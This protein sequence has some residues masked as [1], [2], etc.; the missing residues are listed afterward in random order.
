MVLISLFLKKLLSALHRRQQA[1]I[2]HD[3]KVHIALVPTWLNIIFT[4][5]MSL[6]ISGYILDCR[7]RMDRY[8]G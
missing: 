7:F 6:N 4:Y 1:Q 3:I 2:G 5:S 8:G